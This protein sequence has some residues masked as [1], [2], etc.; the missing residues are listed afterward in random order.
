MRTPP[1]LLLSLLILVLYYPPSS[2][3]DFVFNGFEPSDI[4]LYGD[5]TLEPGPGRR[6]LSLTND[7]AFSLGRALYKSEVPAKSSTSAGGVLPFSASFLFSI[8]PIPGVLPGHGLAFL[9]APAAGTLGAISS[10]NLGLLNMTADGDPASHVLAVEFD[11]FENEEFADINANHVG[12]DVNSLTSVAAYP[13]G[14]WPDNPSSPFVNLTLNDGSNYQAWVDFVGGRLNVT[15]APAAL[16]R[17]PRRPLISI[18]LN[19]SAVFLDEMFVGFCAATGR[20]VEHHRILGWSFSNSNFSAGD[21]LITSDLPNFKPSQPTSSTKTKALV[22]SISLAAAILVVSAAVVALLVVLRRRRRRKN[23]M[24]EENGR[25]GDEAMEDWELEYWPHR[26]GYREI[27]AA[28]EGFSAKNL[29]GYGGNGRVYKGFLA[30]AEVAVKVLSQSGADEARQF[31]AEV[32][33]LG[34]LKHRNLVGLRGWCRTRRDPAA[35]GGSGGEIMILVYDY[36]ENG[37]L[38]NWIHGASEPLDWASRVRILKDVAAAVLYL[39]EGWGEGRVVHRDIKSSNVL[40]DRWMAGRLGDFGL[41]RAHP[42]DR[43]LG[44]SR[45]VGTAGYLAP[46][47]V[48]RSGRATAAMDVYAYGVL[49]LEVVSGRRPAEE[50]RPP[51]V[52][53]ARGLGAAAAVDPRV[54]GMV[55]FDNAE[56]ERVVALALACTIVDPAARPTMRQVVRALEA[57]DEKVD[58]EDGESAEAWLLDARLGSAMVEPG[59]KFLGP[60]GTHRH[61]TFEELRQSMSC[62]MSLSDSDVITE[63]R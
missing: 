63:G 8:A 44:T 62:S 6:Y 22:A 38:D 13:A 37:S 16:G 14:Y 9:F 61:L 54:R 27:L 32:S 26:I 50:G 24:I 5:A 23:R 30:G 1:I 31:A 47:E 60:T 36:M 33:S 17:K 15:M 7:S 39:H 59:P 53:W 25:G 20:L 57:G 2:A 51:L 35:G 55:G 58:G 49:A 46:E 21:G 45:V 18:D 56:V 52:E 41:A 11:V 48:F 42:H 40:L 34:R 3:V 19:L 10:Q 12:V 4:N 29:V 43:A 28:T